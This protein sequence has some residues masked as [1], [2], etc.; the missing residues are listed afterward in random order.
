[1]KEFNAPWQIH[2][3]ASLVV[4]DTNGTTIASTGN[5]AQVPIEVAQSNAK[6]IAAAPELLESLQL[7]LQD[8]NEPAFR[9]QAETAI[10]KALS[11]ND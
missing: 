4:I 8:S 2:K 6:L 1:M 10:N 7:L 5:D 11:T 3:K 9:E